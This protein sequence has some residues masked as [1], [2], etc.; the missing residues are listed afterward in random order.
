MLIKP[1]NEKE[2]PI[3]ETMNINEHSGEE[4]ELSE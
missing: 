2:Q 3:E 4:D 1:A